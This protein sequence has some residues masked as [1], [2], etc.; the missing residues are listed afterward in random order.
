MKY[1]VLTVAREFGSGGAEIA[2]QLAE[3][4]GWSLLD[5]ALVLRIAQAAQVDPDLARRFDE[6]V[7]PWLHRVARRGLSAGA[8]EGVPE[9]IGLSAFDAG[10]M[11]SIASTVIREAH[12]QGNCVIIGRGGQCALHGQDDV[13]HVFVYAKLAARVERARR[14]PDA[15]TEID[16]WV[17]EMDLMRSRYV[18]HNFG[19]DWANPHLYQMMIDSTIG[20]TATVSAVLAAMGWSGGGA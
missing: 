18:H 8:F 19:C 12:R 10:T 5:N 14:R 13:F 2:R 11:A 3:R 6:R 20:E 15:P 9:P 17:T 1:R 4:L 16:K 7:D